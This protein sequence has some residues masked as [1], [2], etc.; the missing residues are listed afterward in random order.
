[1]PRFRQIAARHAAAVKSMPLGGSWGDARW[2]TA[3]NVSGYDLARHDLAANSVV[4]IALRWLRNNIQK[5]RFVVGNEKDDGTYEEVKHP[6]TLRRRDDGRPGLLRRPNPFDSW[7]ATLG[8]TCDCLTLDGN[9]YWLKARGR[10][11]GDVEELYWVP[12]HQIAIEAEPDIRAQR[13]TGPI[14]RYWFT[15]GIY[16]RAYAPSEV[17]HFRDGIDPLCRY[18]G[19]AELKRQAR[20]AA[21]VDFGE[22]ATSAVLRNL[23]S[24]GFLVPKESVVYEG[25][26]EE[27]EMI[28]TSERIARQGSGED[29]GRIPNSSIP[30]DFV[31]TGHDVDE[32][33]LQWILQR[34]ASMI[35]AAIGTNG[36]VHGVLGEDQATYANK[37][38]ARRDAWENAVIPRQ[39]LI[40]D[41]IAA[42]LLPDFADAEPPAE[43]CWVDRRDVDALR[44]DANERAARSVSLY[45]G[46]VAKLDEARAIVDLPPDAEKGDLYDGETPEGEEEPEEELLDVEGPPPDDEDEEPTDEDGDEPDDSMK[47]ARKKKR[48]GHGSS[49]SRPHDESKHPRGEGGRFQDAPGAGDDAPRKSSWKEP[50][51]IDAVSPRHRKI[52]VRTVA[53]IE[54]ADGP[55]GK[56][57]TVAPGSRTAEVIRTVRD[58]AISGDPDRPYVVM[59]KRGTAGAEDGMSS[60]ATER[61]AR[62][63]ARRLAIH[64]RRDSVDVHTERVPAGEPWRDHLT[65]DE[66][67]T[68]A[69]VREVKL[70]DREYRA[71]E[72]DAHSSG[73]QLDGSRPDVWSPPKPRKKAAAE[74]KPAGDKPKRSKGKYVMGDDGEFHRIKALGAAPDDNGRPA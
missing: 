30:L 23:H 11:G 52:A 67:G 50:G 46:K 68:R 59:V 34:P 47:A 64:Y 16:R 33:G 57:Y 51:A 41:E 26:T 32:L 73:G 54:V 15:A 48:R 27:A 1:M 58:P 38:E 2:F 21:S 20:N 72:R 65:T 19:L 37:G 4:A 10:L 25:S 18:M 31:Q 22:R 70:E 35:F 69:Q 66:P 12:N 71:L 43:E 53:R 55:V 56:V 3:P 60:H 63:A 7:R 39:D 42:Q 29:L 45:G 13:D 6:L 8:A 36:L 74:P 61:G 17:I 9:A 5:G 49:H 40:A 44:E 62:R 14:R 28:R 24:G